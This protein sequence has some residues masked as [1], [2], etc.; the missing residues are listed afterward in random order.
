MITRS[1]VASFVDAYDGMAW[2][3]RCAG[4]SV[5]ENRIYIYRKKNNMK[6]N[7]LLLSEMGTLF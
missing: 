2:A 4:E 5:Y 3:K 7:L 1:V 6:R